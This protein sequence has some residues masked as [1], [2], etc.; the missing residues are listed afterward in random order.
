[1]K[2]LK[3]YNEELNPET[4]KNAGRSLISKGHEKRGVNLLTY[5]HEKAND[6]EI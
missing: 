6:I 2:H 1:M 3:R 4:Y 5:G